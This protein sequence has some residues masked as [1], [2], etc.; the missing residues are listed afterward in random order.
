MLVV[1]LSAAVMASPFLPTRVVSSIH[2]YAMC[3][4]FVMLSSTWDVIFPALK[5][6]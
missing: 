1:I 6:P 2:A 4:S 3:L 5:P